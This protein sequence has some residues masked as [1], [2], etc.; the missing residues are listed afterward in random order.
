MTGTFYGCSS[1]ISADLSNYAIDITSLNELFGKC[2]SL[3]N[4]T[5]N[6]KRVQSVTGMFKDCFSLKYLDLSNFNGNKIQL[7]SD[8][9]PT[10]LTSVTV[11]YNSSIFEKIKIYI[12]NDGINFIDVEGYNGAIE[13]KYIIN[14]YSKKIKIKNSPE[15]KIN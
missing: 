15:D 1:L 11:V 8:F 7:N 6:V 2:T 12:P 9:F 3:Q 5:L 4:V 10:E 14:D 13:A